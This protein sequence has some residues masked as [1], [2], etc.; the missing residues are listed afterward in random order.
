MSS[1][2]NAIWECSASIN[3]VIDK[4]WRSQSD[5][6]ISSS[7]TCLQQNQNQLQKISKFR[8]ASKN[9]KHIC[10]RSGNR[11]IGIS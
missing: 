4:S 1:I 5:A 8:G 3:G 11:G 10:H 7:E 6:I 2:E 9:K